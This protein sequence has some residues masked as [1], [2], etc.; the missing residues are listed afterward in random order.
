MTMLLIWG[1]KPTYVP[2]TLVNG[3][4]KVVGAPPAPYALGEPAPHIGPMVK[5]PQIHLNY[6]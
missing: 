1:G 6:F 2:E 3:P 5:N 4:K